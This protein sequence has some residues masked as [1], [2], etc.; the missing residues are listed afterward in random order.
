MLKYCTRFGPPDPEFII[1][2]VRVPNIERAEFLHYASPKKRRWLTDK[3][4]FVK[5]LP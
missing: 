2:T 4:D 1:H 5:S 3:T